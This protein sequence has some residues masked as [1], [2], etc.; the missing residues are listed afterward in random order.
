[1]GKERSN[2]RSQ[3]PHLGGFIQEPPRNQVDCIDQ[4]D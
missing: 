4:I 1:M 3:R 2:R